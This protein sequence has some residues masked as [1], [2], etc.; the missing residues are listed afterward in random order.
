MQYQFRVHW[1]PKTEILLGLPIPYCFL[2]K[3]NINCMH[4]WPCRPYHCAMLNNYIIDI[5]MTLYFY[6]ILLKW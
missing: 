4:A 6:Q 3:L 1:L 2:A 5:I